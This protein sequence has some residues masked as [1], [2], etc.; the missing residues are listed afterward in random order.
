MGPDAL[1]MK[2]VFYALKVSHSNLN[3]KPNP[4]PNPK[5][6]PNLNPTPNPNPSSNHNI[7]LTPFLRL[8]CSYNCG[9]YSLEASDGNEDDIS[10]IW[11]NDCVYQAVTL[12]ALQQC[13]NLMDFP[14]F[15]P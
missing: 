2:L 10:V 12:L 15:H 13:H 1:T 8:L 5:Q 7:N 11:H 3:S 9:G 4:N 6:N 14:N